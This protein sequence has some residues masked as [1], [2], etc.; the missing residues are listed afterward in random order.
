MKYLP[1][2]LELREKKKNNSIFGKVNGKKLKRIN[3]KG[4]HYLRQGNLLQIIKDKTE[5]V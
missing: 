4:Q 3:R 5:N 2:R 1:P